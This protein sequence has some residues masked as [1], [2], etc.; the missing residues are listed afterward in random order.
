MAY[1][2]TGEVNKAREIDPMLASIADFIAEA[3]VLPSGAD[4]SD[5]TARN[6]TVIAPE[7]T[8]K[9]IDA[10]VQDAIARHKGLSL[11]VIGGGGK[12]ADADAPGPR[13]TV[14]LE[15]QLYVHPRLRGEGSRSAL[16]LVAALLRGL[17]DA[18]IRVTGCSW[19][20]EIRA[21]GFDPLPDEDF[22]AY[23]ISFER[24]MQL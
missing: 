24:E 9:Q 23:S 17:H 10:K 12:V 1:Q 15:L 6:V 18:Q 22:T 8:A 2:L 19:F 21:T 11:L 7:A 16:E 4:L 13:L 3:G 20:E 5:F 14:E